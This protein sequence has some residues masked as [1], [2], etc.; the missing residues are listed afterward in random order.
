M[1]RIA[2]ICVCLTAPFLRPA[3]AEVAAPAEA[4]KPA[5]IVL[6]PQ[7][8]DVSRIAGERGDKD[9]VM[10]DKPL[11]KIILFAGGEPVLAGGAL[12]GASPVDTYPPELLAKPNSYKFKPNEKIT[13]AGRFT[14]RRGFDDELGPVFEIQEV[15]GP[16]W[17]IAIHKVYLGIPSEHRLERLRSGDP[18]QEHI[19]FGCINVMPETLQYMLQHLPK[20]SITPV[21]VLPTDQ[22]TTASIFA[23]RSAMAGKSM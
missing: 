5:T 19:T 6:S 21:Y 2:M 4:A 18:A 17:W 3:W 1:L 7:E 23:P 9:F 12:T 14:L 10:I 11:G 20:G 15:H 22:S 13:P 16:D 8:A